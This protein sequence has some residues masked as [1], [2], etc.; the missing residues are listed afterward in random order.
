MRITLYGPIVSK[1]SDT[2]GYN[3]S[4]V[5]ANFKNHGNAN[6]RPILIENPSRILNVTNESSEKLSSQSLIALSARS[7]SRSICVTRTEDALAWYCQAATSVTR[8]EIQPGSYSAKSLVFF[9]IWLSIVIPVCFRNENASA[10][11]V[12]IPQ[13]KTHS[14]QPNRF[15]FSRFG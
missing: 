8:Q 4:K 14:T 11:I 6:L 10:R 5:R 3:L 2:V 1:S 13:K 9:P 12:S 7:I 15:F